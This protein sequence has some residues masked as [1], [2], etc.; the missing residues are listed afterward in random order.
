MMGMRVTLDGNVCQGHARCYAI[1]EAVFEIDDNGYATPL[2]DV[3][4]APEH[5][6]DVRLAVRS[7][8]EQ[9]ISVTEG[10]TEGAPG[11][12]PRH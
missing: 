10:P 4:V 8:P 11:R 3:A 6:D 12:A 5:E 9:A 1:N 7:C 2:L